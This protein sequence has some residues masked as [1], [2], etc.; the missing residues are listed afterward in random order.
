MSLV[1]IIPL[2]PEE[3]T[4]ADEE[5]RRDPPDAAPGILTPAG[6]FSTWEGW[7]VAEKA[8]CNRHYVERWNPS[9]DVRI[10]LTML[11]TGSMKGGAV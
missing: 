2:T 10:V 1:G 7:S 8:A 5:Y 4:A 9:E 3:F 11:Q 6:G